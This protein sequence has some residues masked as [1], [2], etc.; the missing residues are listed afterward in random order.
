MPTPESTTPRRPTRAEIAAAYGRTVPDLIAPGLRVLFS[1]IN[2][3][4]YS[5]VVGHHFARPGNRFWPTLHAAGFTPRVFSPAEGDL[6]LARGYGITNLVDRATA[7]ADELSADELIAGGRN[8]EEK[9]RRFRPAVLAFLGITAYRTAFG[10]KRAVLGR[11]PEPIGPALVWTLPNPSGL[12]AHYQLADLGRLF[13][14]LRR[15]VE[16]PDS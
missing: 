15:T 14:D 13:A 10:R 8:L 1:G 4:L 11:Q 16:G 6:L 2:P 5:A 7:T 3:S 9:I 12:N